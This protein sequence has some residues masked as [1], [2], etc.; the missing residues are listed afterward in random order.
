MQVIFQC[1]RCQKRVLSA[2]PEIGSPI[3]CDACDWKRDEGRHDVVDGQL[4]R[5]RVCGCD[6]LWRQKD[7][8]PGLG[9]LFVGLGIVFSSIAWAWHMPT[10]AIGILMAFALL[11]L[12]LFAVMPDMLVCY[13]CRSRH[14]K[15]A[16]ADD[17][18]AFDLEISERYRQQ[19]LRQSS[20]SS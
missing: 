5:C 10:T 20:Q 6:D 1:P 14:R 2:P 19:E 12:V 9:L 7:F 8:P 17:H 4:C 11:D 16:I 15:S 3:A 18:P 13:R